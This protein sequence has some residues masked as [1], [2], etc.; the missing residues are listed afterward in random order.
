MPP[1]TTRRRLA[2]QEGT[3]I[4]NA[5]VSDSMA[6]SFKEVID[7]MMADPE[8][9]RRRQELRDFLKEGSE[10]KAS[11]KRAKKPRK[12]KAKPKTRFDLIESLDE[13]Q[14]RKSKS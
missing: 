8:L 6:E 3:Q 13:D 14:T 1:R 11:K 7:R 4:G 12:E 5:W 2:G 9:A 10:V